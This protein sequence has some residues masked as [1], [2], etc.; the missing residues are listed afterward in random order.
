MIVQLFKAF[1]TL[2][3][4]LYG[5]ILNVENLSKH[6]HFY[7]KVLIFA[8]KY[9]DVQVLLRALYLLSLGY[10]DFKPSQAQNSNV[11]ALLCV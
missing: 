8:R 11:L 6:L 9:P 2:W 7:L 3:A 4:L 10:R 5:P 1:I